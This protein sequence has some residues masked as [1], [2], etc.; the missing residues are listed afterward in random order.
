MSFPEV[1]AIAPNFE[2]KTDADATVELS[3]YRGKQVVLYFYPKADTPGCTKQACAF[4]DNYGAF[5]ERD[6]VVLGVSPDTVEEQKVFKEK[7]D[8][9][10]TLIADADHKI[11]ELYG[12]WG[13]HS[14]KLE[15]GTFDYT[16]T[17]RCTLI[18]D[19]EG[20]VMD[21]RWGVDPANDTQEVLDILENSM[22]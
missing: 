10:F 12:V 3:D 21:A 6:V 18:I 11:A 5:E 4:R 1:G 14:L 8:L 22:A 2:A 16:G 19:A 7:Y 13:D 17:L 15:Q 9:P 20:K